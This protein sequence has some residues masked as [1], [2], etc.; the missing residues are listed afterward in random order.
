MDDDTTQPHPAPGPDYEIEAVDTQATGSEA[1]DPRPGSPDAW[2]PSWRT[3]VAVGA[4]AAVVG[5]AAV[6]CISAATSSDSSDAATSS[7]APAAGNQTG[8][9]GATQG[10]QGGP[11][12]DGRLGG[13]GTIATIDGSNLTIKDRN[14]T[15][16]KV[17][18][19]SDTSVTKSVTGSL[20]DVKIGDTVMVVG[21][22]SATEIDATRVTDDGKVSAED[23]AR[24][25]PGG[26]DRNGGPPNG[27][28]QMPNGQPPTGQ[29][30][31]GQFRGP[32]SDGTSNT[33]ATRG[34]V[35]SVGDR[36]F[37][38]SGLDGTEVKITMSDSTEVSVAKKATVA[39][40]AVG[41][42]VMVRGEESD[43]TITA[44]SIREGALR[45]GFGGPPPGA[46]PGATTSTESQQ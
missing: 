27:A 45:G 30:P 31:N 7:Q 24:G 2:K 21:T 11:G 35:Q 15:T 13:F 20:A 42:T 26:F 28:G 39:D 34:V 18:T 38:I 9:A 25:G 36:S 6:F 10:Q 5:A 4:S 46:S 44:T 19:S 16:T 14:G 32:G 1:F 41:D 8:G 12:P 40:L 43:G 3:W 22:G 17:V 29:G 33:A 37:T 23:D